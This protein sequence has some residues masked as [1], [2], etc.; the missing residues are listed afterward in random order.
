MRRNSRFDRHSH[1]PS[2]SSRFN[3]S[4][5]RFSFVYRRE[6]AAGRPARKNAEVLGV[7]CASLVSEVSYRHLFHHKTCL[8]P[9]LPSSRARGNVQLV[10]SAARSTRRSRTNRHV[11]PE[12]GCEARHTVYVIIGA[13]S[14]RSSPTFLGRDLSMKDDDRAPHV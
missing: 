13:G 2:R 7:G 1:T 9:L 3:F 12:P 5:L 11:R 6:R 14:I 10:A 4:R 8:S